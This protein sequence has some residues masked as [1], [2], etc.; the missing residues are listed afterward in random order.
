MRDEGCIWQSKQ[1]TSLKCFIVSKHVRREHPKMQLADAENV[2]GDI[3]LKDQYPIQ[4][5]RESIGACF[6][7]IAMSSHLFGLHTKEAYVRIVLHWICTRH[8]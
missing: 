4:G 3:F 6:F 5:F 7:G 1:W 8:R 2:Q